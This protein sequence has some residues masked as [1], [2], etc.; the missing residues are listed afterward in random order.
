MAFNKTGEANL[1][2]PSPGS[3]GRRLAAKQA[4]D[5]RDDT[6]AGSNAE[7]ARVDA[8]E[9]SILTK[10]NAGRCANGNPHKL[11]VDNVHD[12]VALSNLQTLARAL[13]GEVSSGQVLAP[14]PGHSAADRSLSVKLDSSAPDGFLVH[15]F[16]DDDPIVCRDYVR[17]KIG[18]PAFKSHGRRGQ[19]PESVDVIERA[20]MA[21]ATGQSCNDKPK[22]GIV[23]TYDYTDADGT[24][25]YQVV[26]YDPKDFRQRR[27]DGNGGWTWKLDERRILYRWPELV[28]FPHGTIFICEGEKDADRV[29]SLGHCATTVASGKWT[30]ECV[31]TLAGRDCIILQ[32]NDDAGR[33]KAKAFGWELTQDGDDEGCFRLGLPN[34]HQSEFLRA[35]L[36]LR[37]R[38]RATV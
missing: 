19:H 11:Q 10:T 32:D 34:E 25:L 20:V 24:L 7:A 17:A 29:A 38:R 31:K 18:L 4:G 2:S 33:A 27:P 26:R 23:A 12:I 9:N 36:G 3:K 22:S 30:D 5:L 13:S 21:A 6:A 8:N 15:S 37:R 1:R 28:K 16:S 35:L 14:G